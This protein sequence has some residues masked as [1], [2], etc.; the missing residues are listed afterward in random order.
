MSENRGLQALEDRVIRKD[1]C[2]TCGACL[3]LCPYIRS[4]K[5]RIVKLDECDLKEGRCFAYCPR[6][7]VDLD[8]IHR[9][10]FGHGYRDIAMGPVKEIQMA[11]ATNP[12]IREK[13]QNGGV[14]T[15]LMVLALNRG[16]INAAVL[17]HRDRNH[18]PQGIVARNSDEILACAGSSYATGPTLEALNIGPWEKTEQ[19]GLVGLPCQ[20][21]ALAKMKASSLEKRTPIDRVTLVV[22]LFCTWALT[23]DSLLTFLINRVDGAQIQKLDIT[24]P[25][26]RLLKVTTDT[27]TWD[28]R[29]D[30]IRPFIQPTCKVCLDMTSELSDLSVGTV[31][32]VDGWNTVIVRTDKGAELM[33]DAEGSGAIETRPLPEENLKHLKEASILKKQRALS[34]LYEHGEQDCGYLTLT[35]NLMQQIL[36]ERKEA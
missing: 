30:E 3:S 35:E 20:V 32:G 18:L 23:Y 14:V 7:E 6:T 28:I 4:R 22:G 29:L 11:R 34:A 8:A 24:P 25:P 16:F 1:F 19:I 15:S 31:E 26:D 9:F 33:S 2:T 10:V 36:S 13:A 17:T 27:K 5:G 21:L 12:G